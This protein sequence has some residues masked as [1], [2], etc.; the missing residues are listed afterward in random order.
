MSFRE[1]VMETSGP[2]LNPISIV[3]YNLDDHVFGMSGYEWSV[4][5]KPEEGYGRSYGLTQSGSTFVWRENH[6]AF[7]QIR[8]ATFSANELAEALAP[9]VGTP[10]TVVD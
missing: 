5:V 8:S 6:G 1:L 9:F 2:S 10:P 3:V 7:A 4:R